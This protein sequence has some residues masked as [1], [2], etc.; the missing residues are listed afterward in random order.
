MSDDTQTAT[1]SS[2]TIVSADQG[3]LPVQIPSAED[4]YDALMGDIEPELVSTHIPKLKD[5]YINETAADRQARM[6]RYQQAY[7]ELNNRYEEWLT[8]IKKLFSDFKR[9]ALQLAEEEIKA[10]EAAQ[11]ANFDAQLDAIS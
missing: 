10:K 11:I 4:I 6:E 3:V 2:A 9:Q 5:K 1:G 8:E 7:E